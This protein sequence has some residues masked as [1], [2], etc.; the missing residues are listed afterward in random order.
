MS[1]TPLYRKIIEEASKI[2]GKKLKEDDLIKWSPIKI[3]F[4]KEE[5]IIYCLNLKIYAAFKKKK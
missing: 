2:A 3:E 1:L 4:E 5:Y